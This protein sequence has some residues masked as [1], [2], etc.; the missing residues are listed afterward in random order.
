MGPRLARLDDCN[1]SPEPL[2]DSSSGTPDRDLSL[3]PL[4]RRAIQLGLQSET[5]RQY[6]FEWIIGLEEMTALARAVQWAK[7]EGLAFPAVPQENVYPLDPALQ[8]RLG[9]T[10]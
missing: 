2:R 3:R 9:T 5:V 6:V 7:E 10:G 4:D 8:A 1:N